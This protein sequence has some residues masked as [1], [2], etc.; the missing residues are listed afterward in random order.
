MNTTELQSLDRFARNMPEAFNALSLLFDLKDAIESL[1][2]VQQDGLRKLTAEL[3][4]G[5]VPPGMEP[6]RRAQL[7][8]VK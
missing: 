2:P 1:P 3:I 5:T 8:L 7:R 6:N 4:N